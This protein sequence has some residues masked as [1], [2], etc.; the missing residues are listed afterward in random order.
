MPRST[1]RSPLF[2]LAPVIMLVLIGCGGGSSNSSENSSVPEGPSFSFANVPQH[3]SI[4]QGG[5]ASIQLN[6]VSPASNFTVRCSAE[7]L[8]S[9]VTAS[10]SPNPVA[11]NTA[12]IMTLTASSN[13]PI[14]GDAFFNVSG[15]ST[16]GQTATA[17][18]G[19]NVE[20]SS[21]HAS[22]NRTSFVR[23]EDTP[24]ALVYD[25]T[26][27]LIFSSA[28]ELNCVDVISVATQQVIK[29]VPVSGALGVSLSADNSRV[30]VGTQTNQVAWIDTSSLQVVERDVI[31]QVA[32]GVSGCFFTAGY[33]N[34][35]LTTQ[36]FQAAN[37]KV[38]LFSDWGYL[39]LSSAGNFDLNSS[40]I[41]EW[42]PI[43]QTSSIRMCGGGVVSVSADHSKI[44]IGG[45]GSPTVYD[46]ATDTFTP[47]PGFESE[48][49]EPAM[50]PTGTQFALLDGSP[51]ITFFNSQLAPVGSVNLTI[52]CGYRPKGAVYSSD[53][54]YLYVELP[55]PIPLLVTINTATFQVVGTAPTYSSE[56]AYSGAYVVGP[57]QAADATGM[58]YVLGD[59]GVEFDDATNYQSI[60]AGAIPAP[61]VIISTPDEGPL[62]STT[63]TQ[64]TTQ[65]FTTP[66]DAYFGPQEQLSGF[67]Y[68]GVNLQSTAPPSS[69]AGPV[70]IKVIEP[71]GVM[72]MM[73]QGFTYGSLGLHFGDIATAPSGN[74]VDLFGY[75]FDADV[76]GAP[77]S[78]TIG[79]STAS[80]QSTHLIPAQIPYPFPMQHLQV[81]A[82]GGPPGAADIT[83][84]S[85][86]GTATIPKG[87][88]YL[89]SVS[90][91]SSPDSFQFLLYDQHRNCVYMTAVDHVDVF[92]ADTDSFSGQIP[93]PSLRGTRLLSGL[94]L[95][96]DGSKLLV[97]NL[98]DD[99]V[100]II[101]PD[102]P[103]VGAT[104]VN[105]PLTGAI[106][107][108]IGPF[109]I[110][111]TSTNTAF[112]SQTIAG[113]STGGGAGL[114]QLDIASLQ[115]TL[116]SGLQLGASYL[117]S[118]T[119]GSTVLLAGLGPSTN[120]TS[121]WKASTG[122]WQSHIFPNQDWTDVAISGDGNR[123]T[124][125]MDPLSA[126]LFPYVF[127]SQV[128]LLAQSNF[129]DFQAI[130][131]GPGI[132]FDQTGSLIYTLNYAGIDIIDGQ[133][134][135]L[136]E[137]IY[138]SESPAY[139]LAPLAYKP[140]AVD[141]SGDTIFLAT[142]SG[143]TAI[144]LDAVPLG[145][146]S[147]TPS[148]GPAGT[149]IVLRGTGF[150]SG[151]SVTLNGSPAATSF[152]DSSTLQVTIPSS[153]APGVAQIVLAKPDGSTYSLDAG[154]TTQ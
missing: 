121:I 108:G 114:Y 23:T 5:V 78:V 145:I 128:N 18:L 2:L 85:P 66:P 151:T 72:G 90:D 80:L 7:G 103:T 110:A 144:K 71:N 51:V 63:S 133:T 6:I 17:S 150:V 120:P 73:P 127:D 58:V 49:F 26:H 32:S 54:K 82:A 146:G 25:P 101:N 43:A 93:V 28:L 37:G 74:G 68:N 62:N 142:T 30:L 94:S 16:G 138:L 130:I 147:V 13:A 116:V 70:N 92:N 107:S 60:P 148:A 19:I 11:A 29:C 57:P 21:S 86:A 149:Q 100:A 52:C 84:S 45:N 131:E 98:S 91:F 69:V 141:P 143:L 12:V 81:R 139:R 88:H 123:G 119:D 10:F 97:G 124:F 109:E 89:Q 65:G 14:S 111:A 113:S 75:G 129:S 27:N 106:Q 35:P 39:D 46:S 99:S 137:R 34:Y 53:G 41:V 140:I 76:Q 118:S 38:L 154:F 61:A 44:L 20:L 64:I 15:I 115:A 55:N 8:P 102:N 3:V 9:G 122:A 126:F 40:T 33:S 1:F 105:L 153:L 132:Q 56:D 135:Q 125:T 136:R 96:P 42:D 50:N 87:F 22:N 31:P 104:A 112:I 48:V 24:R 79:S 95:T 67:L 47:V 83:I 134:G 4:G 59:H 36:A 117:A 152:V 77:V